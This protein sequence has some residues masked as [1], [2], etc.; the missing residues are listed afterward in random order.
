MD[1]VGDD[2]RERREQSRTESTQELTDAER[3]FWMAMRQ[4]LL[5]ALGALETYLCLARSVPPRRARRSFARE[6]RKV[7]DE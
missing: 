6:T 7:T 4:A 2:Q 3:A 1:A 5:I